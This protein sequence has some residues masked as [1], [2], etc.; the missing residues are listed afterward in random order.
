MNLIKILLLRK[1]DWFDSVERDSQ[2]IFN[3]AT[4]V[5]DMN[6][7]LKVIVLKRTKRYD[8]SS[9][10]ILNIKSSLSSFANTTLD[11]LWAKAGEPSNVQI[12]DID[13]MTDEYPKLRELIFGT[14]NSPRHDGVQMTGVGAQRQFTYRA[15]QFLLSA[16]VGSKF[17]KK[18]T[19]QRIEKYTP[20]VIPNHISNERVSRPYSD[21]AAHTSYRYAV[22]VANKFNPLNY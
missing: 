22:P 17:N 19:R 2:M 21:V 8:R 18:S 7:E 14:V 10:D 11:Q 4:G 6:P 16:V 12:A 20:H 5:A 15:K 13:L 3:L 9:R 1:K